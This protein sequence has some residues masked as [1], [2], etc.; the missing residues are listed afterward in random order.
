MFTDVWI[1][2][3]VLVLAFSL[4]WFRAYSMVVSVVWLCGILVGLLFVVLFWVWLVLWFGIS[5]ML[6]VVGSRF[7][8]LGFG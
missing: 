7:W 3:I 2:L 5:V 1:W 4:V 8:F 6:W